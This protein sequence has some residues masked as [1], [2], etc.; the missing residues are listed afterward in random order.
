V[1]PKKETK[2]DEIVEELQRRILQGFYVAG[3]RLPSEREIAEE[4]NVSRV[5]VRTALIETSGGRY[6]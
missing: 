3:Q 4:L 1:V 6:S 2:I 5:T